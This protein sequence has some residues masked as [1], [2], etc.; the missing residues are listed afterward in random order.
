MLTTLSKFPEYKI[1]AYLGIIA[2]SWYLFTIAGGLLAH[3]ADIFLL[4]FFSWTLALIIEPLVLFLEKK[5]L[6]K[7]IAAIIVYLVIAGATIISLIAIVPTLIS[8]LQK[9]SLVLPSLLASY[10]SSDRIET[11]LANS[12]GSSVLF[13][14]QIAGALTATVLVF[15]LS[16][17]FLLSRQQVSGFILKIIPD[18]FED[19]FLFLENTLNHT[20]A[21]FIRIQIVLGLIIGVSA[22]LTLA[23]LGVEFALTTGIFAGILGAVPVIGALIFLVPVALAALTNSTQTAIIAVVILVIIAQLVYNFLGPK[24]LGRALQIHPI[25]VILSFVIGFKLAGF[26]GAILSVPVASSIAIVTKEF[27]K[28]WHQEADR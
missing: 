10:T 15:I 13:A 3:V 8:Q 23:I 6:P 21:S 11:F 19:D 18:D 12:L 5:G 16:F 26:W 27:L 14:S 25:V 1:L 2:L 24:L 22:F 4:I 28:Y 20:F 9:L 17:Y 7:T